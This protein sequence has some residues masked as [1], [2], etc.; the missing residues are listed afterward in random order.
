MS[1]I[2]NSP[3][4]LKKATKI[5][6]ATWELHRSTITRLYVE[7]KLEDEDGLIDTMT[8]KHGFT[9][10]YVAQQCSLCRSLTLSSKSQYEARFREW[11]LRKNLKRKDWQSVIE[12]VHKRARIGKESEVWLNGAVLSNERV[13][14]EALRYGSTRDCHIEASEGI[15]ATPYDLV[16]YIS[17]LD[18][19][20]NLPEDVTVCT[21]PSV[22]AED[23]TSQTLH[24]VSRDPITNQG[25]YHE[26]Q[27]HSTQMIGVGTG[28]WR[29]ATYGF[30][31]LREQFQPF[32]WFS[33]LDWKSI[34]ESMIQSLQPVQEYTPTSPQIAAMF[35][36]V[37]ETTSAS[38]NQYNHSAFDG[39][40]TAFQYSMASILNKSGSS[41]FDPYYWLRGIPWPIA[42]RIFDGLPG[43]IRDVFRERTFAEA[44]MSDDG[45]LAK[46][47]LE[48]GMDPLE[49]I[50]IGAHNETPSVYATRN[51]KLSALK[52]LILHLIKTKAKKELEYLLFIALD[53]MRFRNF[54]KA[55]PPIRRERVELIRL[56]LSSGAEANTRSFEIAAKRRTLWNELMEAQENG[57][58]GWLQTG[59][60]L[61]CIKSLSRGP[62]L[63]AFL[64]W[65]MK[66][67][68][69]NNARKHSVIDGQVRAALSDAFEFFVHAGRV[70][71]AQ[72]L[73]ETCI[74]M[75]VRLLYPTIEGT[76]GNDTIAQACRS[77]DLGLLRQ[78]TGASSSHHLRHSS[79][80]T[81]SG[82]LELA[83]FSDC[84]H[85]PATS[86]TIYQAVS[87]D[88]LFYI[89]SKLRCE[90][91]HS[92]F[93]AN[94]GR[95]LRQAARL[96]RDKIAIEILEYSHLLG[97]W[98]GEN[99][100]VLLEYG[101]IYPVC[102]SV[103]AMP[104][105]R[106]ALVSATT[107]SNYNMLDDLLRQSISFSSLFEVPDVSLYSV[108]CSQIDKDP[109]N[110]LG[111][112]TTLYI[113]MTASYWNGLS[114]SVWRFIVA[115]PQHKCEAILV[116]VNYPPSWASLLH[117]ARLR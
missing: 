101:R 55:S 114:D 6:E 59:S 3:R 107:G 35:C 89:K 51:G 44:I 74:S 7:K 48:L 40:T 13:A 18:I 71:E 58:F 46:A 32:A 31:P 96:G 34:P 62:G 65:V 21:P 82:E 98:S 36:L 100:R 99:F 87:N 68:L 42:A 41:T 72:A 20:S 9:A 113:T 73:F 1:A 30:K 115:S 86:K 106:Q 29:V 80:S 79:P 27:G 97:D 92:N 103:C 78:W 102:K 76:S 17:S 4:A 43:P 84:R 28:L 61:G 33:T 111:A 5:D 94:W 83:V 91:H 11:N 53:S 108:S 67:L 25:Y 54:E 81:T 90:D 50:H 60:F 8:K 14:R 93:R 23:E 88:D 69:H 52:V 110:F 10:R 66:D 75:N 105:F 57:I 112:F 63:F 19:D 47:M 37:G 109:D 49:K 56:I 64:D 39:S 2:I 16:V 85:P 38:E 15:Y 95:V 77:M 45:T 22:G 12:Q 70:N 117:M 116:N 104:Q 26:R 24:Q